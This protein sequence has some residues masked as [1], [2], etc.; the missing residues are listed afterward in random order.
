VPC[1][2][3]CLRAVC[4]CSLFAYPACGANQAASA[5]LSLTL[6]PGAAQVVTLKRWFAA[7]SV[8]M[9][10]LM[11]RNMRKQMAKLQVPLHFL[12][13]S[14]PVSVC[15]PLCSMA[16][17]SSCSAIMCGVRAGVRQG[18]GQEPMSWNT[19]EATV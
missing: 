14:F 16:L 4:Q 7:A 9:G 2:S 18:R 10:P 13:C 11:R 19:F 15:S 12:C 17:L 6:G 1:V 3:C 5:V 8:L